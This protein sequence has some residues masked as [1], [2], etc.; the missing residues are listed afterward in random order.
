VEEWDAEVVTAVDGCGEALRFR[1]RVGLSEALN[2]CGG[3]FVVA[4]VVGGLM[5][6]SKTYMGVS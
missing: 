1:E 5:G 4:L 6:S 2:V 3:E